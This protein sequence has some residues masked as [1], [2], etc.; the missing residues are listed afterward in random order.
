[1]ESVSTGQTNPSI[2][3]YMQPVNFSNPSDDLQK[4]LEKEK[5][6][7][8]FV[9]HR[10][11]L[12]APQEDTCMSRRFASF[13]VRDSE[14]S[15]NILVLGREG[16]G[17]GSSKT[18]KSLMCFRRSLTSWRQRRQMKN[19]T[20]EEFTKSSNCSSRSWGMSHWRL[21]TF[22]TVWETAATGLPSGPWIWASWPT[23]E[24]S[25]NNSHTFAKL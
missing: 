12:E 3:A 5:E 16:S 23:K 15:I 14:T 11:A 1:M 21:N 24:G 10:T 9:K 22:R 25:R 7:D 8:S 20:D 19:W 17:K 4:F 13:R 6:K 18:S 2:T